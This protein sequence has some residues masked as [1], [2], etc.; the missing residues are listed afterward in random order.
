MSRNS[1]TAPSSGPRHLDLPRRSDIDR[2]A[3]GVAFVRETLA[4]WHVGSGEEP[5][6]DVVLVAAELLSNAERHGGGTRWLE[7]E[8]LDG[9]LRL[10]VHDT[11]PLGPAPVLP[12]LPERTGGHGLYI[13][14]LLSTTWGWQPLGPG[15]AVWAELPLPVRPGQ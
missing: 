9:R 7:V 10:T 8:R 12:H 5:A 14:D 15:K 11:S 3:A 1:A 4:D 6:V 13:V 2:V